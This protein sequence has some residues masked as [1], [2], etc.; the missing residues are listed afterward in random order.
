[1]TADYIMLR[2]GELTLKGR[3]RSR[4][5]K[6]VLQQIRDRLKDFSG[7]RISYEFGRI[8]LELGGNPY[9]PVA[10]ELKK[11]FGLS[12]FSPVRRVPLD[13]EA[14]C[15]AALEAVLSAPKPPRTFK[16]TVRRTN[17]N[18]PYG[19][20]EMNP[21][22]GRHI[23]RGTTGLKVD[24][25]HP[26]LDLRVEIRQNGAYIFS[27]VEEA[28]G[29]FPFGSNGK[30]MLMLSGGIDSPVAGF[31]AL[32][33]GL[34]LEAVHFHSYPF[35]SE[36]AK[37][38]V[39]EL[40]RKLA[41]YAGPMKLHLVP[42][43][44]LQTRLHQAYQGNLEMT[45]MRR[46]MFRITERLALR[47]KAQALVTGESLGQVASQTLPSLKVIGEPIALPI[48]QP[49][50]MMDK[51][52][53]IKIAEAIGTFETSILP[54]EDCCTLFVP[55]HPATNPNPAMVEY[56]ESRMD[57]MDELMKQT[58]DRVETVTI[59]GRLEKNEEMEKYF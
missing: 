52:E 29:G 31:L 25:H 53:I 21:I 1:M 49:L 4:F 46:M 6:A 56:L 57:W 40:T 20:Q 43:T 19:S 14:I 17:K 38:K 34:K 44:E 13:V 37:E 15:R 22:I 18:F 32:K 9:E 54:Y 11:V 58:A 30:A 35:T 24:V 5:E 33:R 45:L 50:I 16:V 26:D 23:L 48:L 2:L 47:H 36:R 10:A 3:N 51:N 42:F 12:S 7:I 28:M 8:Y 55:K 39:I 59:P 27:H 41:D